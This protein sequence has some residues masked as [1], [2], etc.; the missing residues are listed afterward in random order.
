MEKSYKTKRIQNLEVLETLS[1]RKLAGALDQFIYWSLTTN[2]CMPG[3]TK[4]KGWFAQYHKNL[5]KI[6]GWKNRAL[7]YNLSKLEKLGLIERARKKFSHETR[8][9]IRVTEKTLEALGITADWFTEQVEV[10]PENEALNSNNCRSKTAKIADAYNVNINK[11][12]KNNIIS[13]TVIHKCEKKREKK[14]IEIPNS[15]KNVFSKAGELLT[16]DIKQKIWACFCNMQKQNKIIVS[17]VAEYISWFCFSLINYRHQ[18]SQATS[19]DHALNI[20]LRLAKSNQF[21]KP[22]GFDP[23]FKKADKL[24]ESEGQGASGGYVVAKSKRELY[25]LASNKS[26]LEKEKTR[27]T[28]EIRTVHGDIKHINKFL[29]LDKTSKNQ[30]LQ[31]NTK[32]LEALHAQLAKVQD[33]IAVIDNEESFAVSQEYI[34]LYQQ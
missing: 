12:I 11:N 28:L 19:L 22:V 27:L 9:L 6:F 5:E 8:S 23:E 7:Y 15:V 31:L 1:G 29:K 33:Q 30:Q 16:Q 34:P 4:I 32:K 25:C 26:S 14:W 17:N 20:L 2:R 18:V 21:Q 3:E 13:N 10:K 24:K